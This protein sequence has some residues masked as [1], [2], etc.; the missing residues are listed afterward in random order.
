MD[1]RGSYEQGWSSQYWKETR[2]A[3]LSTDRQD[4][5]A[6][7]F[8]YEVSGTAGLG[9]GRVRD[10]SPVFDIYVLEKRLRDLGVLTREL[11]PEAR[12]R[13][14]QVWVAGADH[15]VIRD[16]PHSSF[17]QDIERIAR[18]RRCAK[19]VLMLTALIRIA[20][21]YR[22]EVRGGPDLWPSPPSVSGTSA[23]SAAIADGS[24]E[25]SS[26]PHISTT[27]SDASPVSTIRRRT[28]ESTA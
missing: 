15:T 27:S 4:H 10:A 8:D 25:W 28:A 22:P 9:V 16:R 1:A 26:K 24:W 7:I 17:W 21:S 20:E 5:K 11:K 3:H 23:A 19:K 18:R 14:A 13:L 12:V 6:F 2:G